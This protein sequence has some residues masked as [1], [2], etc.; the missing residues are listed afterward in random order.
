MTGNLMPFHAFQGRPTISKRNR[1]L[2]LPGLGKTASLLP[3]L[4]R[5]GMKNAQFR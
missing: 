5:K 4:S 1:H 3:I 2:V